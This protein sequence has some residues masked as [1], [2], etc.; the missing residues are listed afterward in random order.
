M[1]TGLLIVQP[2]IS[3]PLSKLL[4]KIVDLF[5]HLEIPDLVLV[6][7]I[8]LFLIWTLIVSIKAKKRIEEGINEIK[9]VIRRAGV[10][11][12]HEEAKHRKVEEETQ[13]EVKEPEERREEPREAAKVEEKV[14]EK[15]KAQ[16]EF[17]V[18]PIFE[19]VE[20]EK[21]E[22]PVKLEKKEVRRKHVAEAKVELGK[23][24]IFILSTV[25]DEPEKMY[26]KEGLF[27]LFRTAF[28]T[29]GKADFEAIL[30]RLE[31]YKFIKSDASTDYR[32][33]IELTDKGFEYIKKKRGF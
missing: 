18:E 29:K 24:E 7:I 16:E 32:A 13:E 15:A 1:N 31:R 30:K 22:V 9:R 25:A 21:E 11:D 4:A 6:V 10:E 3:S 23:E 20:P 5:L 2:K 8:F 28:S 27:N 12:V 17:R 33:W 26:Q 19:H 14:E